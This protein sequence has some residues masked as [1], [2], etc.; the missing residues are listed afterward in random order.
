[1][2]NNP[3]GSLALYDRHSGYS[4]EG[5]IVHGRAILNARIGR[6]DEAFLASGDIDDGTGGHDIN[7]NSSLITSYPYLQCVA[8]MNKTH[9]QR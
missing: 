8:Y 2:S 1:M 3:A 6:D 4:S 7:D 5:N 9:S